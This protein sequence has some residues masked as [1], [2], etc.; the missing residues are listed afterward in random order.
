MTMRHRILYWTINYE[1]SKIQPMSGLSSESISCQWELARKRSENIQNY[2]HLDFAESFR[3][4]LLKSWMDEQLVKWIIFNLLVLVSF[5]AEKIPMYDLVVVLVWT[6]LNPFHSKWNWLKT[7]FF[8]FQFQWGGI[9]NV[10]SS[11]NRFL[12]G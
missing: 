6:K 8:A 1:R 3:K 9:W 4:L 12:C 10:Y 5:F 11:G 2:H 7:T